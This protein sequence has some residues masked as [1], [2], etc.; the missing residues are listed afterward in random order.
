VEIE[1]MPLTA[2]GKQ[3]RGRLPEA[4]AGLETEANY[5]AATTMVEEALAGIWQELLGVRRVG[6]RDNFFAL[7]GHS[8]LATQLASRLKNT[9]ELTIPLRSLFEKPTVSEMALLIEK[10]LIDEIDTLSDNE[11]QQ[12][13]EEEY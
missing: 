4:E 7:G 13:L 10:A 5:E 11:V 12:L 6:V 2:N 8:L 1:E 9:F 3:D